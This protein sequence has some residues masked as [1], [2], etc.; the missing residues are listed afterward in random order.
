MS[1]REFKLL[2][3]RRSVDVGRGS[4]G[5][6]LPV[7]GPP[8]PCHSNDSTMEKHSS[9][10]LPR[11][12][13]CEPRAMSRSDFDRL[14]VSSW[15]KKRREGREVETMAEHGFALGRLATA[16]SSHRC[17]AERGGACRDGKA[18]G[19]LIRTKE[20][21]VTGMGHVCRSMPPQSSRPEPPADE[22]RLHAHCIRLHPCGI[23]LPGSRACACLPP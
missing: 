7:Q 19:S 2:V 18:P 8:R 1:G 10:P 13:R 4:V 12:R 22:A 23:A 16:R 17:R 6:S 20:A 11:K 15:Y 5:S 3:H 21:N 14:S 9:T